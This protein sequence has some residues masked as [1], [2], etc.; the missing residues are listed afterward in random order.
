MCGIAGVLSLGSAITPQD[1]AEA[2]GM[3]R[4]LH[5]RG[6]DDHGMRDTERYA[7][8][9]ARLNI[10]DLSNHGHMPMSNEDGTIWLTY[11]GEV[12]NFLELKRD[13]RLEDSHRFQSSSDSEVL[14]HLYEEL[15]IQF[16][17]ELTGMFAFCLIDERRGKAF[18]VRDFYGIRPLFYMQEGDRLYFASEIKSFMDLQRFKPEVNH[19]AIYH[20][21]SLAYIPDR[22][23]PFSN[24]HEIQGG[25]LIEVDLGRPTWDERDYY[26]VRYETN[27]DITEQEAIVKTREMM[28]DSVR[29]NLISDAPLGLTLSGGFDTS[30]MLSIARELGRSTDVHTFS[31]RID[32][33]S[34]DET[35]YQ[36]MMADHAK[37]HHHEVLLRPENVMERFVTHMAYMDEPS[38]DGAAI[39]TYLLA[40][41]A[42][43]YVKVLLSGE[44]G[45]EVFNAYETHMAYRVRKLYRKYVPKPMRDL[46]RGV[47]LNLP[48]DFS[49]LSFDFLAK[50]FT[51]GAELDTPDAHFWWRR[52]LSRGEKA[53]LMPSHHDFKDTERFFSDLFHSLDFPDELNRISLIDLKYFF[54]GDLMVKN[55]RMMMAHSIEARFPWMDRILM[56]YVSTI[57]SDMRMKGFTRRWLQKEAMRPLVPKEIFE[58]Q[59]MGLEMPHSIWFLEGMAPL[60]ER[61]FTKKHV[62]RSGFMSFDAIDRMWQEHRHRK[63]DHGRSLWCILNFLV[64]F[65]LFVYERNFKDYLSA[66]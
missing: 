35:Y 63:V 19:E 40:E 13:H 56:E 12:T 23:T 7:I 9:S 24:I 45:D 26:E 42:K 36:R 16:I 60:A 14:I 47:A 64:W 18:I 31:I 2:E 52:S 39:P 21:L 17:N 59:N 61:Y 3:T 30:S 34:F 37:T 62:E 66:A 33:P 32:E 1:I 51:T 6:P 28:I 20:F 55:D 15:G 25:V 53:E 5:H 54:I 29:R 57:P 46:I 27:H 65:D 58:R 11:N 50:R 10:I 22:L 43:H 4:M 49:K 44:G 48:T 41:D 38:G 8:G